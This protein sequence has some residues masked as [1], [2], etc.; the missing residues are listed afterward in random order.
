MIQ[1]VVLCYDSPSKLIQL[2]S[3]GVRRKKR[4]CQRKKKKR[5]KE[6]QEGREGEDAEQEKEEEVK[7]QFKIR[8]ILRTKI[9]TY[10]FYT[11][12]KFLFFSSAPLPLP[13][14]S[15]RISSSFFSPCYA[16]LNLTHLLDL[17]LLHHLCYNPESIHSMPSCLLKWHHPCRSF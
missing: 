7:K 3:W 11:D 2:L 5:S 9:Q 14:H 8:D 15:S 16:P 4:G 17:V 10:L 13:D 12:S 1:S 6:S